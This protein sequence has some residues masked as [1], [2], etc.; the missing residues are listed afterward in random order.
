[1]KRA[2]P[3]PA[4]SIS[5]PTRSPACKIVKTIGNAC[6]DGDPIHGQNQSH[7]PFSNAVQH[8][9][10]EQIIDEA[11]AYVDSLDI[12][13]CSDC[14]DYEKET[15]LNLTSLDLCHNVQES[16]KNRPNDDGTTFNNIT[17]TKNH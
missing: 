9:N 16:D 8:E 10:K 11:I 5:S 1:M 13:S 2:L 7:S 6:L 17:I 14:N 15:S 3:R 12:D 4:K